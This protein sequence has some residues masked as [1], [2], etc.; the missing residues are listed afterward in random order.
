MDP[1]RTTDAVQRYLDEPADVRRD[2]PAE[3]VVRALLARA[4][5]RLHVLCAGLLYRSY[6]R[7]TRGPLNLEADELLGAVVERLLKPLRAVR[8][9]TVRQFFALVNQHMR[10][11][12][13]DL[14]RRLD[15]RERAVA[16]RDSAVAV[17]TDA[18][19]SDPA[20]SSAGQD[21]RGARSKGIRSGKI[22]GD[23][24]H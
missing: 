19:R 4:V 1:S 8:P 2:A 11:E 16:L 13:N 24:P 20:S 9:Q 23:I 17:P 5:D 10:W 6:P 7:L 15:E 12:L 3:P 14:A 18:S 21:Q 22:K